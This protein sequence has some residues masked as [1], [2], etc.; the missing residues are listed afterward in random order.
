MKIGRRDWTISTGFRVSAAEGTEAYPDN[1][2][3][4]VAKVDRA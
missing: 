3:H 2:F 4:F 1:L